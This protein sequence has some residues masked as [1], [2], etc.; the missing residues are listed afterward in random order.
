M[1]TNCCEPEVLGADPV[2]IKWSVVRGDTASIR[3]EFLEN[4][5]VTY[6]DTEGWD[7]LATSYDFRADVL[8]ELE[9]VPGNGYVDIKASS[10]IT[11]NWG[12]GYT[13][14]LAELT[15]DLQV[16][17]SDGITIWTPVVGT[18]SVVADVSGGL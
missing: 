5:E 1:I 12:V 8:D 4:D 15:F 16:T 9:V 3:V 14:P 17:M 6:F 7:Y 2:N 11:A 18:I 13:R 10:D